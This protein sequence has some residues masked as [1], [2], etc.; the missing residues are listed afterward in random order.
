MEKVY[1]LLMN[2]QLQKKWNSTIHSEELLDEFPNETVSICKRLL[3]YCN[4]SNEPTGV[5]GMQIFYGVQI[6]K[7]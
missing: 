2:I 7:K 1:M 6:K 5:L 3:K 4:V